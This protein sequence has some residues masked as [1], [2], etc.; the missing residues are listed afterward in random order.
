MGDGCSVAAAGQTFQRERSAAC[1]LA[2][3]SA[4]SPSCLSCSRDLSSTGKAAA[5]LAQQPRAVQ[6]RQASAAQIHHATGAQGTD[7]LVHSLAPCA[8]QLCQLGVGDVQRVAAHV[9]DELHQAQAQLLLERVEALAGGQLAPWWRHVFG[10][11]LCSIANT[12]P[13]DTPGSKLVCNC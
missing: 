11:V 5:G 10:D 9:V 2:S 6:L 8:Y 3:A 4:A 12:T 7:D 13:P 1:S